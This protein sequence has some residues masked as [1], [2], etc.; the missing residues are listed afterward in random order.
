MQDAKSI[1][2]AVQ[3][4]LEIYQDSNGTWAGDSPCFI[5]KIVHGWFKTEHINGFQHPKTI[6]VAAHCILGIEHIWQD[7]RIPVK[8]GGLAI[9]CN[10]TASPSNV[11]HAV[12]VAYSATEVWVFNSQI[13]PI[14]AQHNACHGAP[15]RVLSFDEISL[16]RNVM[17]YDM[18]GL[19]H[20][21]YHVPNGNGDCLKMALDTVVGLG[22]HSPME[23]AAICIEAAKKTV[24]LLS[25][26]EMFSI[27]D[28]RIYELR[29]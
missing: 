12:V 20:P 1:Q 3:K 15:V 10:Q 8:G 21:W 5:P 11:R 23:W 18:G 24:T 16:V 28:Q 13:F 26:S 4:R 6:E 17:T 29:L 22:S 27:E 9:I 25:D 2:I 19:L 7:S 14:S